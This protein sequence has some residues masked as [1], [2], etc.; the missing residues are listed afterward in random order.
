MKTNLETKTKLKHE[1]KQLF[2]NYDS[3]SPETKF[4]CIK[5]EEICPNLYELL[6]HKFKG[7]SMEKVFIN[8]I[9]LNTISDA[10]VRLFR[11]AYLN[12]IAKTGYLP[13]IPTVIKI[14]KDL[15]VSHPPAEG[16][17]LL[18]RYY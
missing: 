8:H 13:S 6:Q 14:A 11:L 7:E 16:E 12:H 1:A 15:D 2:Q 9:R 4:L 3:I 18:Y 17:P 5:A 10:K